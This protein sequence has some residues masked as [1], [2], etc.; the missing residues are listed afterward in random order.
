MKTK[1]CALLLGA[2][3]FALASTGNAGQPLTDSQLDAISAG[4]N[5][6]ATASNAAVAIGNFDAVTITASNAYAS[7]LDPVS[8][9]GIAIGQATAT[10]EA[11]SAVTSSYLAVGSNST[12]VCVG[13]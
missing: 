12:A 5:W 8:H 1:F 4:A 6:F 9:N 2:S 7:Q 13:C 10:G 11:A 3:L